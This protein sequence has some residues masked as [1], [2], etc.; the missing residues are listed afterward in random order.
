MFDFKIGIIIVLAVLAT[1]QTF[2]VE[3]L[4]ADNNILLAENKSCADSTKLQNEKIANLKTN[5]EKLNK[6]LL[7]KK[8]VIV[9]KYKNII[10]KDDSCE[11]KLNSLLN[12][13]YDENNKTKG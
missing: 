3:E 7:T 9:E 4:K 13:F 2:R 12:A 11:K 5:N 8:E 6:E 1:I 10:L